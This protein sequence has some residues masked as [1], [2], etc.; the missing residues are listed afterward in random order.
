MQE[1]TKRNYAI[2]G[3]VCFA[4]AVAVTIFAWARLHIPDNIWPSV[5]A[6]AL[7]ATLA[8]LLGVNLDNTQGV[9]VAPTAPILWTAACVLGP[10]PSIIVVVSCVALGDTVSS[11][12]FYAAKALRQRFTKPE[13]PPDCQARGLLHISFGECLTGLLERLGR[14]WQVKAADSFG[15]LMQLNMQYVS[16]L[17]LMVG[18]GGLAYAMAG[19]RFLLDTATDFHILPHFVFPFLY[20]VAV[21]IAV[22]HLYIMTVMTVLDPIPGTKGMQGIF[23]R[24]KLSAVTESLPV[25]RAEMFLVVVAFILAYLYANISAWAFV[26]GTMP[27]IALRDI[28]YQWIETRSAYEKTITTLATYMQQYHPY[29]RGHLKRVADMSER[30]ARELRLPVDSI[31]HISTA[32][33]LHDIGKVG[34]S[35]EILDKPGRPSEEEWQKITEHPVK[36]A[37]IVSHIEY[38]EGIVDWIKYHHKWY[39]GHG[40]PSGNGNDHRP[41]IEAAIISVAD[42]FDAMTDD[43]ELAEEWKCD[44][45]GYKVE[46]GSRPENC[47]NCGATK[48]RTYREPKSLDEAMDELRRGA[49]SQFH[50]KV[51][52]AFLSMIERDGLHIHA[53]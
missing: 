36:G 16:V 40:Y 50:P 45:C 37:D 31:R 29:T 44:V 17:M 43:R 1:R 19:G 24:M 10:F 27:V 34:V 49:G 4:A 32:G 20:L 39:D 46:D 5:I 25:L 3:L 38:F 52:K 47:P 13:T 26:L 42:A 15:R 28:F 35:E 22:E 2:L 11:L 21:S 23:L 6:F 30:L 18:L 51:V 14:A 8:E 48:N 7:F 9:S 53:E 33:F 41:P 12:S